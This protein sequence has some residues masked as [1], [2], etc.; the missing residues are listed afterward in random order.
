MG[1]IKRWSD[2]DLIAAVPVSKTYADVIRAL[3]LSDRSAG[4][5]AVIQKHIKRLGL[6]TSHFDRYHKF[7]SHTRTPTRPLSEVMVA[8]SIYSTHHLAKRL[9]KEGIRS[10]ECTDCGLTEWRGNP[11]P[12][13]LDH[14]NGVSNDH[15]PENVRFLCP[16]CHALTPTWRGRNQKT[17]KKPP[18]RCACGKPM[19]RSSQNCQ[20]CSKFVWPD[21]AT[22]R[23][24]R[25]TMSLNK[26]GKELGVSGQS[27]GRRLA[28]LAGGH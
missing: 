16:N 20:E 23:S 18:T 28:R 25:G 11:I 3:G 15:R 1:S 4:N 12:L 21:E 19:F 2:E 22:L 27:V 13:E 6:D 8:G 10:R 9:L 24:M 17:V 14:I 26:M 7:E 5:W